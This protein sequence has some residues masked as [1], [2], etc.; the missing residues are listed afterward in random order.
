[1]MKFVTLMLEVV[2]YVFFPL[3]STAILLYMYFF[4]FFWIFKIK[5][6]QKDLTNIPRACV[7]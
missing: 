2:D 4:P 1:M 3:N 6:H 7:S 5:C